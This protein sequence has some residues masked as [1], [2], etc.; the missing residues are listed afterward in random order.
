MKMIID[1]D[2]ETNVFKVT[3]ERGKTSGEP[4]PPPP[5]GNEQLAEMTD[6]LNKSYPD[7]CKKFTDKE[8]S[9]LSL[10]FQASAYKK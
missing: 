6:W 9:A 2:Q 4:W 10:S 5:P 7:V 3:L 1:F 8:V